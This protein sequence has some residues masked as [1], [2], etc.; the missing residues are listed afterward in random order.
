MS[1][2]FTLAQVAQQ[3]GKYLAGLFASNKIT[4]DTSTTAMAPDA[5]PFCYFH[6]VRDEP[7]GQWVPRA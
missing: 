2:I 3:Q 7:W 4:G 6:K 5:R 1:H